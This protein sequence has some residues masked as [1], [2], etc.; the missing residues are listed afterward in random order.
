MKTKNEMVEAIV[1]VMVKPN[2]P[3]AET[4]MRQQLRQMDT[5]SLTTAY[6]LAGACAKAASELK[7]GDLSEE[8]CAFIVDFNSV[9]VLEIIC[10][11]TGAGEESN[12]LP[13]G[14]WLSPE[15]ELCAA[16]NN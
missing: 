6:G 16:R 1:E 15:C 9:C 12:P 2:E 3:K 7:N 13:C 14:L 4:W 5:F 10:H 11:C 8:G